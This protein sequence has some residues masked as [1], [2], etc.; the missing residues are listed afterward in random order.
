MNW[1]EHLETVNDPR[2]R[3]GLYSLPE[4]LFVAMMGTI[5]GHRDLVAIAHWAEFEIDWLRRHLPYAQGTPSHDTLSRVL[6]RI[7]PS[8]LQGLLLSMMQAVL[9]RTIVPED[10]ERVLAVDGKAL[11]G[12]KARSKGGEI[13][14]QEHVVHAFLAGSGT[15]L[16]MEWVDGKSNEI[17]AFPKLLERIDLR[18]MVVTLDAMGAQKALVQQIK[19][20]GS[21]VVVSLKGNQG[22]THEDVKL[23][24]ARPP[25]RL[26]IYEAPVVTE[27]DHGRLET[28]AT[29]AIAITPALRASIPSMAAW[30]AV[31]SVVCVKSSRTVLGDTSKEKRFFLSTLPVRE[32]SDVI[33]HGKIIRAHWGVENHLHHALDAVFHEDDCLVRDR[34]CVKNLAVLRRLALSVIKNDPVKVSMN[35]KMRVH[36]ASGRGRDRLLA[37]WN[38]ALNPGATPRGLLIRK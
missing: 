23:L 3:H 17:T 29:F 24:F 30:P 2:T 6:G 15:L 28:R 20:S 9:A 8:S 5:C 7:K 34:N 19:D 26:E 32:I 25:A 4:I 33:R 22:A 11:C 38:K 13:N 16:G 1:L 37:L 14:T 35:V 18:A 31:Q 10:G 27:K 36:Y 12:S 21:N